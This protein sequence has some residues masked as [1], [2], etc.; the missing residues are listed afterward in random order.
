MYDFRYRYVRPICLPDPF[1]DLEDQWVTVAGW[2][3]KQYFGKKL[4]VNNKSQ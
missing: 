2:G 4:F 3:R 1:N